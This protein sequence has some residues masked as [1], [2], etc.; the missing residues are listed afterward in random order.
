MRLVFR[1]AILHTG[2][3]L[4][5]HAP[6]TL[7]KRLRPP[8]SAGDFL[9]LSLPASC[10]LRCAQLSCHQSDQ[11]LALS[12]WMQQIA[13]ALNRIRADQFLDN[14]CTCSRCS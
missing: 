13:L 6:D 3:Q 11:L 14:V 7:Q 10:Q 8:L 9:Q 1:P 2:H 4:L 12:G 5:C